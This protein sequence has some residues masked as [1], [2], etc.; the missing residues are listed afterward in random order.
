M[1]RSL[2]NEQDNIEYHQQPRKHITYQRDWSS[3]VALLFYRPVALCVCKDIEW[4][5]INMVAID[6]FF[7]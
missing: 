1:I 3:N 6:Y 4:N 2:Q 7:L 5:Y